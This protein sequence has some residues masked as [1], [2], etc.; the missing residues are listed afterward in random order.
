MPSFDYITAKEFREALEGDHLEMRKCA[1][2]QAWK[3]VQVL[4]GSMVES[5]LIDYLASST[6]PTRSNKDPLKMDLGEAIAICRSEAVLSDRT[7]DLC[8]VIKSYRNLIHPGRMVRLGE[9]PPDQGSSTIAMALIDI[10]AEEVATVRRAA[11]G[12]TAEQILSKVLRDANS[13]TILKHLL[14]EVTEQQRERLL[15]ELI[16]SAH[17]EASESRDPFD[18]FDDSAERLESAYRAILES[19]TLSVR[20]R[21]A[22]EFVRVLREEDGERVLK[23]GAAFFRASDLEFVPSQHQAM[24]REHLLGRVSTFHTLSTLQILEGIGEHLQPT[25]VVKW[26]DPF[27]R[28][29]VS[30][31]VKDSVKQSARIHLFEAATLTSDKVDAAIDRRLD[32]WIRHYEQ[33]DAPEKVEFVQELKKDLNAQRLPF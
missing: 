14:Q 21:V 26:L 1:D 29:L 17:Q 7:A 22:S 15:L 6:N 23:Y 19:V 2:A 11:V 8:S 28:T 24:V 18:D 16:P 27:I 3:S 31:T 13:L 30:T 5:L 12:L 33:A 9:Q 32:D 20:K 4:A 10:I 25:D